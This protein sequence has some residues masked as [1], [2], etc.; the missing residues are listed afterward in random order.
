LQAEFQRLIDG[1]AR[2]IVIVD[3][4][5][6]GRTASE[7]RDVVLRPLGS[8]PGNAGVQFE[9]R[10][11]QELMG[12][13]GSPAQGLTNR[14]AVS[15]RTHKVRMAIGDDMDIVFT[16]DSREPITI[17]GR[18]GRIVET[19]YPPAGQTTRDVMIDLLSRPPTGP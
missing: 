18:D 7:L 3:V 1:G 13:E 12:F 15:S 11:L 2:R 16:P 4:Y 10:W 9:M 5:M 17:F 19:I 8:R 14:G 6:G